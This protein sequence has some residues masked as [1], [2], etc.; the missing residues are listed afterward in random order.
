MIQLESNLTVLGLRDESLCDRIRRASLP[1]AASVA[2]ARSGLPTLLINGVSMHSRYDPAGEARV[3]AESV[4][5]AEIRSLGLR[6]AVFGLGLG[7][8]VLALAPEFDELLV[9]EPDPGLIRLALS[10]LD[11]TEAIPRLV[12]LIEPEGAD[13]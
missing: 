7:H 5:P 3:W 6:P 8:H 12:F 4:R 11:F 10:H 1:E 9:I 2:P 13:V